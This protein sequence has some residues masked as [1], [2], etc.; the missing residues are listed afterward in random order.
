M[1]SL[2]RPTL[3]DPMGCSPPGSS[4]HGVFQARVLEWVTVSFSKKI[5]ILNNEPF[6]L[7]S[8]LLINST[9]VEC[10]VLWG[11]GPHKVALSFVFL[12]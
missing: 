2:S 5:K 6:S 4:V 11:Q 12:I 7:S 8:V 10:T 1:R 3:C 9:T